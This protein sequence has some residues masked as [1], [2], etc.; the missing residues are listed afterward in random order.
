MEMALLGAVRI[1]TGGY[2]QECRARGSAKSQA[3]KPLCDHKVQRS[4]VVGFY[5]NK[6]SS[7]VVSSTTVGTVG[8]VRTVPYAQYEFH[9][10]RL[11]RDLQY[12]NF[13]LDD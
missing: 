5:T 3:A 10:R 12:G 1:G 2:P 8:T 7:S 4:A 13:K 11:T 9:Y 6:A